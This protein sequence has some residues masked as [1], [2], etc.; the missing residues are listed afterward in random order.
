MSIENISPKEGSYLSELW[1]ISTEAEILEFLSK[2]TIADSSKPPNGEDYVWKPVGGSIS[3]AA[4]I[5]TTEVSISPI[6][7]RITNSY[8]ADIEVKEYESN[9]GH[10]IENNSPSSPRQ[11]IEKWWRIKNGDTATFSQTISD[12]ERTR[13]AFS[14]VEVIFRDSG[15]ENQPTITI[16]DLGIGQHPDD[17]Q[18]SLLRLGRSNKISRSHLHGTYGHGGSSAFRFCNY[19]IIISRRNPVDQTKDSNWIGWTVIRKNNLRESNYQLYDWDEQ[20][21]VEI[22]QPPVYEYL[23]KKEGSIPRVA[24]S[25]FSEFIGTSITH[26]EYQGKEWQNLSVGLG[27]RLFRNYLF[28]PVLP[29]RLID[30]RPNRANFRRN[31]FGARSTLDSSEDVVYRNESV[32]NMEEN[33]SLIFRYWLLHKPKEPSTRPIT[34]YIERENSRNTIIITLNGQRHGT[35]EKNIISKKCRLPRVADNLLVQIVIDDLS[36]IMKGEL[37]TST[38]TQL[39]Q[40]GNSSEIVQSKLIE[41]ITEDPELIKWEQRLSDIHAAEDDSSKE[42]KKLLDRMLNV[43][44]DIGTGNVSSQKLAQGV[45][46]IVDYKPLDP[47]TYLKIS[48]KEDPIEII[49]GEIRKFTLELNAPNDIFR[50]RI[51]KGKIST[52]SNENDFIITIM[53]NYFK[54]GRLPI[55][56]RAKQ[57]A[58]E[59][60]PKTIKF[61]YESDNLPVSLVEERSFNVTSHQQYEA[62]D[63]PTELK[64][65]RGNPIQLQRGKPNIVSLSFNGPNDIL[66]RPVNSAIL[67]L[68]FDYS[69]MSIV[70]R[71]GPNNGKIQFTLKVTNDSGPGD[72]FKINAKMKLA[73]NSELFDERTCN[74]IEQKESS[75]K[76]GGYIETSRPNYEIFA[77]RK[78]KW[79]PGWTDDNIGNFELRKIDEKDCLYLYINLDAKNVEE[80]RQRR[81]RQ[82]QSANMIERIEN[83]YV[84]HVA[85]HLFLQFDAEKATGV[86]DLTKSSVIQDEDESN[87]A[88]GFFESELK[89]VS[90]TILLSF[91]GI[92][93]KGED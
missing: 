81:L 82:S 28:D 71:L 4:N 46:T 3:N 64:F 19:S 2:L 76:K 31:M 23:C 35:F 27:Y 18:V 83:K 78:E 91:R 20:K 16:K 11:A 93:D 61:I 38:R 47:P 43:G 55:E 36:K 10:Q 66:S 73:D 74:I 60:T 41:C 52:I 5:H 65:Q 70:R 67:E 68:L 15:T 90:K 1:K 24:S 85:Y 29:F 7:E 79:L 62:V 37:L 87:N 84:A 72:S 39:V 17:F 56:I 53:T 88:N 33:G 86:Y 22:K 44:I 14:I 45:G 63:P 77:L 51:N 32:E 21:I 40:E 54:N 57:D 59:Y 13:F 80:D 8:D 92:T 58:E 89:R 26:I 69:H 25:E 42:I 75:D 9:N 34:N 12:A 30:R 48:L 6:I 50:R 49:K